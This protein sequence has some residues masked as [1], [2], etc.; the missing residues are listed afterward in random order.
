MKTRK[1]LGP[2]RLLKAKLSRQLSILSEEAG[3]LQALQAGEAGSC[4]RAPRAARLPH[5]A[6]P[7]RSGAVHG[8]QVQSELRYS[9][10]FVVT[11]VA[12]PSA[13][14]HWWCR[15]TRGKCHNK[16]GTMEKIQGRDEPGR[17]G[18]SG[19]QQ[20][21]QV[22][23]AGESLS[24]KPPLNSRRIQSRVCQ[25]QAEKNCK[26]TDPGVGTSPTHPRNGEV[27]AARIWGTKRDGRAGQ[28]GA[29]GPSPSG[30]PDRAGDPALAPHPR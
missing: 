14:T 16:E 9:G 18:R 24:A 5:S 22:G 26:C 23:L 17:A 8:D 28:G 20:V 3:A 7:G 10:G 4:G 6:S 2:S 25:D 27:F 30:P 12:C 15:P 13:Q 21:L 19:R 1:A 11:V 29:Q